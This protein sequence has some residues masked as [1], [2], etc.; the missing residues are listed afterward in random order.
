MK[1]HNN[2]LY[3]NNIRVAEGDYYV[4]ENGFKETITWAGLTHLTT[5]MGRS[6]LFEDALNGSSDIETIGDDSYINRIE[7]F[8]GN[9]KIQRESNNIFSRRGKG[10]LLSIEFNFPDFENPV[11]GR[12]VSLY[13]G[14]E[15]RSEIKIMKDFSYAILNDDNNRLDF[16]YTR[17]IR[18]DKRLSIINNNGNMKLDISDLL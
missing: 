14:S 3:K 6:I 18:V 8:L 4:S 2:V 13:I 7:S 10:N 12:S 11:G 9:I 5:T 15:D 17:Y 1:L 16:Y